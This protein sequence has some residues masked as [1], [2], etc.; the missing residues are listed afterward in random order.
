MYGPLPVEVALFADS[1]AAWTRV[2]RPTFLG[3]DRRPVRSAGLTF[4]V[5]V[6]GFAVAQIDLA[7]PF[8]RPGCGWVWGFSLNPGF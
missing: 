2:E 6:L 1:G 3:G 4:R 8:E 7:R 5:N